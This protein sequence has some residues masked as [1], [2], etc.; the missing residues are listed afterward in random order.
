MRHFFSFASFSFLFSQQ[1]K[2]NEELFEQ[3]TKKI[4]YYPYGMTPHPY[5]YGSQ[6]SPTTAP[7]PDGEGWGKVLA[8][9]GNFLK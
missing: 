5:S 4:Q 1:R 9:K 8:R 2:E 3:K 7:S 6:S